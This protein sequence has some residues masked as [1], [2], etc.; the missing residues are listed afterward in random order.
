MKKMNNTLL[1]SLKEQSLETRKLRKLLAKEE[2]EVEVQKLI[3]KVLQGKLENTNPCSDFSHFLNIGQ[4]EWPLSPN[5]KIMICYHPGAF[6]KSMLAIFLYRKRYHKVILWHIND[7]N[8][9][10]LGLVLLQPSLLNPKTDTCLVDGPLRNY[11]M[12][13]SMLLAPHLRSYS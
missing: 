5:Q 3:G 9:S 7:L 1:F 6:M 13:C 10:H 2:E 4:K 8:A 11:D 12:G